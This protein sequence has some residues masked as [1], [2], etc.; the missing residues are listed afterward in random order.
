MNTNKKSPSGHKSSNPLYKENMD[1]SI[2][3]WIEGIIFILCIVSWIM[4]LYI[5]AGE[6]GK[7]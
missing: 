3:F 7:Q 1:L 6:G 4:I 5:I 2:P